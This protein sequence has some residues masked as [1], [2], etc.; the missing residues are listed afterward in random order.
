MDG[1]ITIG[2]QLETKEFDQ[3]IAE[4]EREIEQIEKDLENAFK[5]GLAIDSRP[6]RRMQVD[7]EKARNKLAG[8]YQQKMKLQ[9]S[10]GF[11]KIE[12]S[13]SN[14]I[15]RAGRFVVAIFG[16]RSAYLGLMRVSNSLA[17]YD[18]QYAANLE[19]IRYVLTQTIAPVLKW[20]VSAVGTVLQYIYAILEAWFGIASKLNLSVESFNKMKA[21]ASG[22]SKAVK[23]IKKDLLGFDEI[24]RLTEQG[25]VAG[26]GGVGIPDFDIGGLGNVP[27]WLQWIIDNKQTVLNILATIAAI[28]ASIKIAQFLASFKTIFNLF[29]NMANLKTFGLIAG[30][31]ITI[32]GIIETIKAL[33]KF[34]EDPSWNNFI[35]VLNGIETALIGVGIA[36]VALNASNPV[37]WIILAVAAIIEYVK[38]LTKDE[39]QI[40]SVEDAHKKLKEAIDATNDATLQ[41]IDSVKAVEEAEKNLAEIEK[42][43]KITGEELQKQVDNGTLSYKDMTLAQREVYEAYVKNESAQS[44]LIDT[45]EKLTEAKHNQEIQNLDT[46]LSVA[47]ENDNME[48]WKQTVIDAWNTNKI[49]T[50]EARSFVERAMSDMSLSA[51]A[52]FGRDIPEEIKK[53]LDP[54]RYQNP[55]QKFKTAM[56]SLFLIIK[57]GLKNAFSVNFSVGGGSGT[58][59]GS[60]S[61]RAKGGIFYP[62]MLPKLAVGGIINQPGT[63]TFYNGAII[64]ERGAEAVV[65]LTDTQQMELLG[66]TIGRY[67]TIN[68]NIVNTMNGRVI[69][70]ELKQVQNEQEFA[71]NT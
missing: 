53:G 34:I 49:K 60:I 40:L 48:E 18:Q 28:I 61:G 19:Y 27:Q 52:T 67:I 70:R 21:G 9:N 3:Q 30:L 10:G 58:G 41:Y 4:L 50:E 2:T 5:G 62:S 22:V 17:S 45:T 51:M 26:A 54:T 63:G 32:A 66:E 6:V 37:G 8:L 64:G 23:E 42:R 57:N 69:S 65:P 15:K 11:E 44:R 16:I 68:A 43:N 36:M 25:T 1:Y 24:N 20:I 7:L 38:W 59:G 56:E 46:A 55:I 47:K 29:S 71:Y 35:D 39:A 33:I 31:A 12:S 13:L 14:M